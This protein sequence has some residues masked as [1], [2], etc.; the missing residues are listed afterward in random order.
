MNGISDI[1]PG[2]FIEVRSDQLFDGSKESGVAKLRTVRVHAED[3]HV[4][5]VFSDLNNE[6]P[7]SV[8]PVPDLITPSLFNKL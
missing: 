5:S 4:C 2:Q 7:D 1:D 6:A 3:E 8:S